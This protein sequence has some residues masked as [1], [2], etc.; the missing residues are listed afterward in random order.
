[1]FWIPKTVILVL[2][3][4]LIERDPRS[5]ALWLIEYREICFYEE[6]LVSR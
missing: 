1:M 4:K 5:L 2:L 6:G 3:N